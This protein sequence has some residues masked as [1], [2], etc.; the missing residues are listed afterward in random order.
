[1]KGVFVQK[2]APKFTAKTRVDNG[3]KIWSCS[4]DA[5]RTVRK[6]RMHRK[7]SSLNSGMPSYSPQKVKINTLV[8]GKSRTLGS[9]KGTYGTN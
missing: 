4:L 6:E 8:T 7:M 5:T 1:M 3:P 9:G 2:H